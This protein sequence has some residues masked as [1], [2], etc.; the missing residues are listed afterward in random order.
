MGRALRN[1]FPPIERQLAFIDRAALRPLSAAMDGPASLLFPEKTHAD[2]TVFM[3]VVMELSLAVALSMTEAGAHPD[4]AAGRSMGEYSAAAFTGVLTMSDC[5]ELVRF[6]T[7]KGQE[8][9]LAQPSVLATVYGL[10]RR[11]LAAAAAKVA[12]AGEPC[13]VT[14]FYDKARLGVAGL[15]ESALP[16]LKKALLPLRHRLSLSREPGAFHTSL[17]DRLAAGAAAKFGE[18]PFSAPAMPLYMNADARRATSARTVREKLAAALNSPVLWQETI[19]RML[20]D[21]VRNFVELAPGAMLTEFV[22]ELPPDAEVLRTDTPGNY[23]RTLQRL[24]GK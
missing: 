18:T 16:L 4:A 13:E 14:V 9:C 17:F 24:A 11:E 1:A 23:A 19:E 15:R 10:T 8:D 22:C 20:A 2:P 5:F 7:L 3:E 12:A 21:G 6:V